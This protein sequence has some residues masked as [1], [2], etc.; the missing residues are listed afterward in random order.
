[1]KGF[2]LIAII[3]AML[4]FYQKEPVY[5]VV[6]IGAGVIIYF[7]YKAKKSGKGLFGAFLSGSQSQQDSRLD[8]LIA[9]IM[10]QQL[11]SGNSQNN[12]AIQQISEEARKRRETIDKTQQEV[13]DLLSSD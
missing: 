2:C 9:L 4:M 6:I 13:L 3:V 10:L 5:T 1:M 7:V 12:N 11:T 8:D